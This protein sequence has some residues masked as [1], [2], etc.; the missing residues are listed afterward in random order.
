MAVPET[1]SDSLKK[2]RDITIYKDERFYSTFPSVVVRPD[3]EVLCAF[4]RA[5]DRQFLQ[6]GGKRSHCD[7]NSYLVMVRS[8]DG[9]K[10]WSKEPELIFAHPMGGSQ[11]PCMVQL[12]DGSI[13]CTSYGW[14]MVHSGASVSEKTNT[15]PPYAF[16]GGYVLRSDN[17]GGSWRGPFIPLALPGEPSLTAFG[18][19][20]P[21]FNRGA[22]MQAPDGRLLWAVVRAPDRETSE[23]VSS[24][25]LVESRDRAE[26]WKYVCPVAE[27]PKITF[28]ETSLIQAGNGD[29]VAFLRTANFD[30]HACIARSTDGGKTFAKWQDAGFQGHPLHAVKLPDSRILVVYGYRHPPFGVRAR[31]LNPDATDSVTAPEFVLRDDGGNGDLGY[32]WAAVLPDG[33]VLVSYYINI[34]DGTRHIAGSI[35]EIR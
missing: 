31:I 23:R 20:T 13:V 17:G 5:P 21:T 10:T 7:S 14:T 30:D 35:L 25:H 34:A 2:L 8:K 26:T 22:M 4:R 16:M 11:D 1:T 33:K 27:D 29:I 3:G 9:C 18:G 15:H 32:P 28:N 12:R 6:P 19:P 24:V